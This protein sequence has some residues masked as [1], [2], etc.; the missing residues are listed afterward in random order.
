MSVTTVLGKLNKSEL[1]MILPH[2]HLLIDMRSIVAGQDNLHFHDKL[3]MENRWRVFNDPYTLL[4]NAV[5]DSK[6]AALAELI[7]LKEFMNSPIT[8][9]DAT[10]DEIGRNPAAL[11]RLSA[12][13]GVNIVIGCGFYTA[14][15]HTQEFRRMTLKEAAAIVIEDLT[16]GVRDTNIKAGV[17]GEIGTSAVITEHEYKALDAAAEASNATGASIH[18]HTSLYERN[19]IAVADK[20][21]GRGVNPSRICIN[22]IDVALR[23][24][25]LLT[26]LDK[27]VYIE[28][29]N[30]GKEFYIPKRKSGVLRGRFA[31]DLERVKVITRLVK[32]GYV[33]Q[34]LITNDICL[35]SMLTSYG[36]NGYGHIFRNIIPMLIS[37]GLSA[38]QADILTRKNPADF[39]DK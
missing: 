8:V 18:V 10:T 36:G 9:V 21:I 11:K 13:S 39:L 19:G 23:F 27:G 29:D 22:H 5:I 15:A 16:V 12:I 28:F 38:E 31:Y 17:I 37:E 20:L 1:G 32:R 35:K 6:D 33:K 4:D 25:Y 7:S 26:L 2:E 14:A 34:I 24:D 30:F 3:N